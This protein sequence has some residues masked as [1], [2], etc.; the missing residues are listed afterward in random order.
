MF[1][2]ATVSVLPLKSSECGAKIRAKSRGEENKLSRAASIYN[3]IEE[4]EIIDL[5]KIG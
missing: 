5:T 1:E 4:M 2:V 3:G